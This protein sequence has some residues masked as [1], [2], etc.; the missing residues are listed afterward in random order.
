MLFRSRLVPCIILTF[1]AS[2][3]I[4]AQSP[5][6]PADRFAQAGK[7]VFNVKIRESLT[8]VPVQ[9]AGRD[10]WF[11]LDTGSSRMLLDRAQATALGLRPEGSGSIQGAG[12][13]RVPIEFLRN[14]E[15]H[16]PGLTM[17]YPEVSTIDLKGANRPG[18]VTLDGILGH[19]F[20][21]RYVVTVDYERG[22]MTVQQSDTFSVPAEARALPIT[23]KGKWP[24]AMAELLVS[25]DVTIQDH[26]LI[27]SGSGDAVDHPIV[28]TM[29]NKRPTV[30]G[31]GL[32]T[33]GSGY[34]GTL[35]G[36]RLAA[37]TL[38]DLPISC[39]GATD[40]TSRLIGGEVL[41]HFT[42]IFDYPHARILLLPNSK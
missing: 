20:L 14:V 24:M 33:P 18:D 36:L 28:T 23:F 9:I 7:S 34:L 10:L 25:K 29:E 35:W 41:H 38:H 13:G 32:G 30:S 19:E 31:V 11:V 27:D 6:V 42:V 37:F 3:G 2:G 22:I 1:L 4:R 8:Y 17:E 16:L 39:C 5:S 40:D 15:L 21:S 26:F 12:A